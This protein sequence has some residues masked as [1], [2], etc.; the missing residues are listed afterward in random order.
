MV[1]ANP[2]GHRSGNTIGKEKAM[3]RNHRNTERDT[4]LAAAWKAVVVL[5]AIAV[6]VVVAKEP[7][8][9]TKDVPGASGTYMM[10]AS[11][12]DDVPLVGV[13]VPAS[14]V[15][16]PRINDDMSRASRMLAVAPASRSIS[17]EVSDISLSPTARTEEPVATF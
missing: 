16:G 2:R 9:L 6:L 4:G 17:G 8:D 7:V 5:F 14:A 11:V 10:P 15:D 1:L 12:R 13:D 3:R